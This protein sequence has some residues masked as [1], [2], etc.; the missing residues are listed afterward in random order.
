[1]D[2]DK[3]AGVTFVDRGVATPTQCRADIAGGAPKLQ[4]IYTSGGPGQQNT[5][6]ERYELLTSVHVNMQAEAAGYRMRTLIFD[7]TGRLILDLSEV[8]TATGQP[9][10]VGATAG[11]S[12]SSSP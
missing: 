10:A 8:W 6:R 5:N 2:T 4:G 11:A 12:S 3:D 9:H 1:M 7:P